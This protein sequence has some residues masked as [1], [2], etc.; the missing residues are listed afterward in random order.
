M[1][2]DWILCS[3]RLPPRDVV[4]E[5]K[6]DDE[7]GCRNLQPLVRSGVNGRL[8]FFPDGSMYVYYTP[9]HWRAKATNSG[10]AAEGE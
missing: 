3:N 5:T 7:Q 2:E 1:S 10:A 8:W 4:V 9:T 6:I